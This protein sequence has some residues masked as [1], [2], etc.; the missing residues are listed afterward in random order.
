MNKLSEGKNIW[1]SQLMINN[2]YWIKGVS[3][4]YTRRVKKDNLLNLIMN[5]CYYILDNDVKEYMERF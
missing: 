2:K 5:N 3:G 4:K 1:H